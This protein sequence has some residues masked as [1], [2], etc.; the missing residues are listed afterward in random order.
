MMT[1]MY[2]WSV[3]VNV[4]VNA[5]ELPHDATQTAEVVPARE[6]SM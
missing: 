4:S 2:G 6:Q 1:G 3:P 5:S